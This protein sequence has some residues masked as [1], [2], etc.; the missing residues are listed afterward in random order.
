MRENTEMFNHG[1]YIHVLVYLYDEVFFK[2]QMVAKFLTLL[3]FMELLMFC[4]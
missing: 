1:G 2:N 3:R 4:L